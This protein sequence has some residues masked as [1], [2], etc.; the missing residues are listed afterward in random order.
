[1]RLWESNEVF[2]YHMFLPLIQVIPPTAT[3]FLLSLNLERNLSVL[4]YVRLHLQLQEFVYKEL[5]SESLTNSL[6]TLSHTL[7]SSRC[8]APQYLKSSGLAIMSAFE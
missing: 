4:F 6:M 3:G 1:M 7:Q 8:D 2:L 5:G